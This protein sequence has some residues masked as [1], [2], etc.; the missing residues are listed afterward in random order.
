[1]LVI[2]SIGAEHVKVQKRHFD[3]IEHLFCFVK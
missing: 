3:I 2:G 1:M